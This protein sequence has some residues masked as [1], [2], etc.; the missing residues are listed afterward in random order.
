M[1]GPTVCYLAAR[2]MAGRRDPLGRE[3]LARRAIRGAVLS[4]GLSLVPLIT[5]MQVADGMIE[6]ISARYIELGTYHAQM[7]SYSGAPDWEDARAAALA[8]PEVRGAWLETQGVGIA[9]AKGK[10]AGIAVR[11]VE[12]GFLDDEGSIAYLELKDGSTQLLA[13]NDALLGAAVAESLGVVPGDSINLIT[14]RR[15]SAGEALPRVSILTVR[16]IVSGGYRELDAQWLFMRQDMAQR[17]LA[18]D[19]TRTILGIK[20]L[21]GPGASEALAESLAA[22][23]QPGFTLYSWKGLQANLYQS[24]AS[25]RTM[26]LLIMAVT[27]AVASV[28]VAS[29]LFTL[30][31]ERSQEIA[32]LK[33]LGAKPEDLAR[34]FSLGGAILGAAGACLGALG[35]LLASLW[36]NE[37]IAGLEMATNALRAF[38]SRLAGLPSP[39]ATRLL[40]PGYYLERIPVNVSFGE[41]ATVV[42]ATVLL[43]FACAILPARK[44]ARLDPMDSFR[45][46]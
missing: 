28:N 44:A 37:I 12:Q 24:L 39:E 21:N 14:L 26:L 20:G 25:T 46:R 16:G 42:A 35:G 45:R 10:K 17:F 34:V 33:S 38:F 43:S 13:P 36:V 31:N 22:S 32:I 9:Y 29:A 15:S 19:S 8:S 4:V 5:V 27:V 6:G 2:L 3:D 1:K 18:R 7:H 30:V 11:A 41:L 23:I 40:D